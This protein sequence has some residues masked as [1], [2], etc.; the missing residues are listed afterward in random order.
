MNPPTF[1]EIAL[2]PITT[3]IGEPNSEV[4]MCSTDGS[5]ITKSRIKTEAA[6][7]FFGY[8]SPLIAVFSPYNTSS[9]LFPKLEA[10]AILCDIIQK[11]NIKE[12]VDISDSKSTKVLMVAQ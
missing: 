7:I 12:L 3:I 10:I 11:K 8:G 9:I 4:C 2:E 6:L 5:N 1:E